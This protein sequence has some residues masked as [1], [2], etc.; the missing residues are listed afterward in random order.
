M[1]HGLVSVTH[2]VVVDVEES[3]GTPHSEPGHRPP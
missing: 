1:G 2:T 3:C